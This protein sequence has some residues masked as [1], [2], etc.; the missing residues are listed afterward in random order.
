VNGSFN[1]NA[2]GYKAFGMDQRR[3]P[4]NWFLTGNLNFTLFGYSAPFSFSYSNTSKTFSQPFNQ[5]HF[6]PQPVTCFT[7]GA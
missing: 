4:L 1:L 5:F 7:V 2:V 6:A 3:D